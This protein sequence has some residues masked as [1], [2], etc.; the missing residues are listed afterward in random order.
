VVITAT[1][2]CLRLVERW[3]SPCATDVI[4]T[5]GAAHADGQGDLVTHGEGP[6]ARAEAIAAEQSAP[7][8]PLGRPLNQRSLF[9]VG[10]IG[11]TGVAATYL[12][13]ARTVLILVGLAVASPMVARRRCGS[14]SAWCGN[15]CGRPASQPS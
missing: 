7:Q 4:P 10:M 12:L 14:C 8:Q 1:R 13:S 3:L 9:F 11:A 5:P 6:I 2:W 15:L